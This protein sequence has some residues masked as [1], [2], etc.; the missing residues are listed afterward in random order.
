MKRIWQEIERLLEVS[1]RAKAVVT[2]SDPDDEF[3]WTV[4]EKAAVPA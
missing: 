2:Q 1:D 3:T 4:A